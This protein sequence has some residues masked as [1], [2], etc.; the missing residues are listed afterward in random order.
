[1]NS[2]WGRIGDEIDYYRAK[3]NKTEPTRDEENPYKSAHY[4]TPTKSNQLTVIPAYGACGVCCV[5]EKNICN[6]QINRCYS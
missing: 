1:M 6:Q 4:S 3:G 5:V 2:G